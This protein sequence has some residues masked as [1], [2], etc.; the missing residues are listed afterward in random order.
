MTDVYVFKLMDRVQ[1]VIL[2]YAE[3]VSEEARTV[4]PE[5]FNNNLH[6]QLGHIITVS[7]RVVN[8]LSGRQPLL[9]AAYTTFFAPGT[10][11][12]DWQGEP[13]AWEELIEAIRELPQR[14]RD[15]Y[16]DKLDE[17]LA[18]TDNFAKAE[19]LG[20]LVMLNVG[21]MN[22][23]AGMINAMTRVVRV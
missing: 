12:A 13:P 14:F 2:K 4:V 11:P 20:D 19:T 8:G 5:G 10:K 3:N 6:W 9:P 15:A 18:N 7:D 22:Q 16:A 17:P 23:H 21:H 1:G